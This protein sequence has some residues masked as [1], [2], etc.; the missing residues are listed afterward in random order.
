L[1][2]EPTSRSCFGKGGF[3]V[4]MHRL[5]AYTSPFQNIGDSMPRLVQSAVQTTLR[6]SLAIAL[7]ASLAT[8]H[9]SSLADS[10]D[11]NMALKMSGAVALDRFF[12]RAGA[13]SVNIKTKS[14]ET[15]DVTGPIL[16]RDQIVAIT[17]ST[18]N[19]LLNYVLENNLLPAGATAAQFTAYLNGATSFKN[20]PTQ[21]IRALLPA[22]DDQTPPV[23]QIGT[24]KGI[25]AVVEEKVGT[26]GLSLGYFLDDEYKWVVEAYVLAKPVNVSAY[27]SGPYVLKQPASQDG[28]VLQPFSIE[29]QK[30]LT[31]KLLPPTVMLGRYWG[32]KASKFRPY[33]GLIAMYAMMYDTKA[34][35]L[36]NSYV[37]GANPGDTTVSLKNTFGIGPML[38]MKYQVSDQWHLS[39]NVGSVKLKTEGTIV[40]RNSS[41]TDTTGATLDLG[42]VTDT[43]FTAIQVYGPD[44]TSSKGGLITRILREHPEIG[45]VTGLVTKSIAYANGKQVNSGTYVRKANTTLDSTIFMMSVGRSF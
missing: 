7:L 34:T 37:G 15:Y 45:G 23:T 10:V 36:L 44:S 3:F 38:G 19:T 40:T 22:L 25:K 8:W 32:D 27:I 24:P 5:F 39:L 21:G 31:S 9:A 2:L 4:M 42:P 33:T 6:N 20:D 12:V 1:G 26:G 13:I 41:F 14:G 30:I 35:D 18:D 28:P 29:G 17:R 43:L 11:D 16:T